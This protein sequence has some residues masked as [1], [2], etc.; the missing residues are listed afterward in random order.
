MNQCQR[1][2]NVGNVLITGVKIELIAITTGCLASYICLTPQHLTKFS[3][4]VKVDHNFFLEQNRFHFFFGSNLQGIYD[5]SSETK[6]QGL[7]I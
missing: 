3:L 7:S 6:M 4:V 5:C 1:F 2:M